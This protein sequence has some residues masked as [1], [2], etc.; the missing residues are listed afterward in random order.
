MDLNQM[1]EM[2]KGAFRRAGD[3]LSGRDVPVVAGPASTEDL[4]SLPTAAPPVDIY[5]NDTE[6][7]I[8]ADVPGGS[9]GNVA[10]HV[11]EKEGLVLRVP[12][13]AMPVGEAWSRESAG[14]DWYR[15]FRLPQNVDGSK[16]HSSIHNG[17]L[18]VRLP[19]VKAP[20]PVKIPVRAEA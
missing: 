10:V 16:A 8:V 1:V 9:R 13:A 12:A 6:I 5:E 3:K 7:L 18:T 15:A 14:A 20:D 11:D 2:M 19:K 4:G 17:V